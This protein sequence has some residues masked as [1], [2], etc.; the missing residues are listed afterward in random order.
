MAKFPV[1][2][3]DPVGEV[4]AINYLLSGPSASGQ[5][6]A[7]FNGNGAN[8]QY[9]LTGN[10]RPPFTQISLSDPH[11]PDVYIYVAPIALSTSE[12]LDGRTFKF[13]FAAAQGTAPFIIGQPVS[14]D[15]VADD[16]YNGGY[17]PIGVAECTTTYVI[18]RTGNTYA[19]EAPSTGGTAGLNS[20]STIISTDCNAK[21]T[22]TGGTDRVLVTAQLNNEIF[23]A[24]GSPGSYYYNVY[25]NRYKAI[26][27]NDPTNPDFR[28]IPDGDNYTIAFKQI[29][30]TSDGTY[31]SDQV[32]TIF[33]SILDAPKPAYYW[34]IMEVEFVDNA[35]GQIVT[36]NILTQ[37][38]FTAQVVK[39]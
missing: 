21:V 8:L 14:I 22:V 13:T 4:D 26:P 12:M 31:G 29:L 30:I 3:D 37:R 23:R 33:V 39:Q 27:T 2:Y 28:F 24:P 5:N 35:G 36:S 25:I 16:F 6:L 10:Y 17:G 9:D 11:V 20:M 19:I 18:L 38:S 1:D 32:E 34:Y 7:G 15:G